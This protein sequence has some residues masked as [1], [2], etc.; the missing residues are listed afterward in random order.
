[1]SLLI[2]D[3]GIGKSLLW[4]L[5][6]AAV[7][8]GKPLPEFGIPARAPSHV[9]IA[10]LT[11][12]DWRTV[13][14]P[15]LEVAGADLNMIRV[16]CIDDDG[17]GAPTFPH[18]LFLITEADPKPDL[19]VVDAWL[20]TVPAALQVRDTQQARQALHPW[21]D[22]ATVLDAALLLLCHTNRVGTANARDRYGAT[23]ALRQKARMT[24]FAQTDEDR[25]LVVGPEKA[26]SAAATNAT[27]FTIDKMRLLRAHRGRRRHR[28]AAALHRR[29]N[30]DRA[31]HLPTPTPPTTPAAA[32]VT[33]SA[34]WRSTWPA[35]R[36]GPPSSTPPPKG[37][38]TA[39]TDCGQPKRKL[40]VSS[41]RIT[42]R[43]WWYWALPQ[44]PGCA[45]RWDVAP[46]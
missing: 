32:A 22:A 15:R 9:I 31:E 43:G 30:P 18:D 28:P 41:W 12:D 8:T 39:K 4:V 35:A 2:G 26:N 20:D 3:E 34:G 14:R 46:L 5:I 44:H 19:V 13:V 1:M 37:P 6:A 27:L 21:K 16:I 25:N 33:R 40:N 23:V 24:L 42:P 38:G 17:S 11:E 36:A 10:A 29:I 45:V 7:T